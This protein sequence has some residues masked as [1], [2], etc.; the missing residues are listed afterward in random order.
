MAKL[1]AI[2]VTQAAGAFARQAFDMVA[3]EVNAQ[4]T[5]EDMLQLPEEIAALERSI[6]DLQAQGD[7]MRR[8]GLAL[9]RENLSLAE[10]TA[11]LEAPEEAS[12]GKNAETRKRAMDA[13]LAQDAGIRNAKAEVLKVETQIAG[14]DALVEA[15]RIELREKVNLFSAL[16]HVADLQVQLLRLFSQAGE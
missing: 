11:Q 8:E 13:H 4:Q 5:I 10:I 1:P 9:A 3:T 12:N 7:R 14:M 6:L 2:D 15:R 16:R